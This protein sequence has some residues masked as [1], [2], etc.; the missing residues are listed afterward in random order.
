[1]RTFLE[2]LK[3]SDR[4]MRH[5]MPQLKDFKA[6]SA[7]L[8]KE[9]HHYTKKARDPADLRP[10]QK[11]FNQEKVSNMKESGDWSNK[12][13][14]TSEDDFI[15]DGHHRWLAAK[16]LKEKIAT[17]ELDM[18]AESVFKFVKNKPYVETK[19]LKE[20]KI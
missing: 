2:F 4:K 3:V 11:N 12:P 15:I 17:C 5:S 14:I 19:T 7:D 9:G 10:T 20:S 1:M 18:T 13:I 16:Q 6:F 8:E